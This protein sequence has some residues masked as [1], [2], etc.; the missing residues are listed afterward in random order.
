MLTLDLLAF[1]KRLSPRTRLLAPLYAS[2][3]ALVLLVIVQGCLSFLLEILY[4]GEFELISHSLLV[5]RETEHLLSSTLDEQTTIRGYLLTQDKDFLEPYRRAESDFYTSFYRL[6]A[7]VQDDSK[8]LLSKLRKIHDRWHDQFVLKVLAGVAS[9]IHL[10]GKIL[11][12]PMREIV[13]ELRQRQ[14]QLLVQHKQQLQY[15]G[16]AKIALDLFSIITVLAGVGWNLWLLR[17]RVEKPLQQLTETGQTWRTGNLDVRLDY[18]SSD[19]IGRLAVVL[20][21]M[22]TEIRDRQRLSELSNQ[23]LQDLISALSHDLRTPLL[24]TRNTLRPML[25][26]AFGPVSN[27]WREVLEEYRQANDELIKLVEALLD[28]S[29]YEAGGSQNLSHEPL[30]WQKILT[31]VVNRTHTITPCVL[32]VNIAPALPTTYGDP[33]EIQR[34]IQNLLDNAVRVSEPSQP[35]Q[36]EVASLGLNQVRVAVQDQGPGIVSQEK[37]RLF[38]RFMQGRNRQGRVGLGLYLCRQII[39]AHGGTI[40]VDSQVGK[41][42]TFWFVLPAVPSPEAISLSTKLLRSD[43]SH[44]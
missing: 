42:S 25:N 11:F 4:R 9:R 20:D 21:E 3:L 44:V 18:T 6:H 26:G 36:L 2:F 8:Q 19:E 5:E 28:V 1:L 37:E 35:I 17:R 14:D 43:N 16:Q 40:N 30:D 27:T 29:R 23:R 7:L 12:D 33:V 24:A 13:K 22:A 15:I 38:Y 41:G 10:P 31:Q 32:D 34:V 39:E